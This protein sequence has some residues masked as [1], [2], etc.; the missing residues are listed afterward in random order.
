[1]RDQF[2]VPRRRRCDLAETQQHGLADCGIA[3]AELL[4]PAAKL[5]APDL[6]QFARQLAAL[7]S[8]R[9]LD[10]SCRE[11][12][13]MLV[14]ELR[15]VA[16]DRP[17]KLVSLDIFD[18]LLLRNDKCEARRF[19]EM[20]GSIVRVLVKA[21]ITPPSVCD[22]FLARAHATRAG[23]ACEAQIAGFREAEIRRIIATQIGLLG[24][25][26]QLSPVF[27]AAELE[28]EAANV[29][30][31]RFLL[32]A[33]RHAFGPVPLLGLSD[34]YL[35]GTDIRGLVACV[36]KGECS[37]EVVFSSAD[38]TPAKRSGGA[39]DHA[40]SAMRLDPG[41]LLH[42]GDDVSADLNQAHQHGWRAVLFPVTDSEAERRRRDLQEFLEETRR[43]GHE[44]T[45]HATS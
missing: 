7:K 31:N 30:G 8:R 38:R 28:Y 17:P 23:Y 4:S 40:A 34:M 36:L 10:E 39:F 1:M 6:G 15:E 13:S 42:V 37:L 19:W 12:L 5:S 24:L 32:A 11:L 33:V 18:T 9:V 35:S 14:E 26:P 27:L 41:D 20:S 29:V 43:N 45:A 25:D 44:L 16:G 2:S 22:L 3:G 21:G